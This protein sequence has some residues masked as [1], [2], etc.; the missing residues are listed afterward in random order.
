MPR[1]QPAMAAPPRYAPS[2]PAYGEPA[3]AEGTYGGAAFPAQA[4]AAPEPL[5]REPAPRPAP[6]RPKAP[7]PAPP[8]RQEAAKA[9]PPPPPPE[10]P[11]E[12]PSDQELD[13]MLGP[14]REAAA[15]KAFGRPVKDEIT[16]LDEE[17]IE[18]LPDPTPLRQLGDSGG[19]IDLDNDIEPE[20][21]PDPDPIPQ[22]FGAG[23][24][25]EL[26]DEDEE[27][28]S[29]LKKLIVPAVSIVAVGVIVAG[30]VLGRETVVSLWPGANQYLYDF[31]GL[32]VM[33]PCEGL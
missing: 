33:I 14:S 3:Y 25:D 27:G 13:K 26:D 16:D 11:E 19:D 7:Q 31:V 24:D 21:I 2:E 6:E 23:S 9:A 32:H 17:A 1:G 4:Y 28:G 8:R 15:A 30:L 29:G 22:V 5:A 10:E 18:A 20:D 12:L